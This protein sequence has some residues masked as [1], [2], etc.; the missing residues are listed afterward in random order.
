MKTEVLSEFASQTERKKPVP[1]SPEYY[2]GMFTKLRDGYK[3]EI[4]DQI[5]HSTD[6][7]N[8]YK[9]RVAWFT[10]LVGMLEPFK[11]DYL[12]DLEDRESLEL[13]DE[14]DSFIKY[15]T[16]ADF[17]EKERTNKEDIDRGDNILN[18]VLKVLENIAS[19]EN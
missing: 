17:I 18:K 13:L 2:I 12:E 19:H 14:I 9:A 7:D 11:E 4:P 10:S 16:S 1:E 6:S 8:N 5:I 3:N 15:C